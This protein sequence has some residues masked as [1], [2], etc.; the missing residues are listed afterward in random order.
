[1]A[2][3]KEIPGWAQS[4]IVYLGKLGLGSRIIYL[5]I[6][7]LIISLIASLPFLKFDLSVKAGGIIR[8]MEE[9]IEIKAMVP[10]RLKHFA[11]S[12]G[13]L[14]NKGDLIFTLDDSLLISEISS[15]KKE[16]E[17][18]LHYAEDL[19]HLIK[20]NAGLINS[21]YIRQQ[22]Q[23]YK[24]KVTEM[25]ILIR[26][27][28]T[29]LE[30]EKKLLADNVTTT[31]KFAE[32]KYQ[33]DYA[34]ASLKSYKNQQSGNWEDQYKNLQDEISTI[35]GE[36]NRLKA[37]HKFYYIYAPFTGTIES[38]SARYKGSTVEAGQVFC[39]LSPQ[40]TLLGECYL[41]T[42]KIAYLYPGQECLFQIDAFNYNRFG[43]V[44]G[45][46]LSIDQ[47]FIMIDNIPSYRVKC[48]FETESLSL[49]G[50]YEAS[51]KKGMTF[52]VRFK[53]ISRT[54]WELLYDKID[55]WLNPNSGMIL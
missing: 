3:E 41:P 24:S 4:E 11:V 52:N 21:S 19:N 55:N 27:L 5:I 44:K 46:I 33:L 53:I 12:E 16:L 39:I 40:T 10:G 1:M 48:S 45:K 47:D 2:E 14:V 43:S 37:Q 34:V 36:I 51:L 8:P 38:I 25:N 13:D 23:I 17:K 31:R 9:R 30:I 22:Y 49:P 28:E 42:K 54:A 7:L 35:T 15:Q 6:L 29:D 20:N 26:Q 32:K 18:R 50:G